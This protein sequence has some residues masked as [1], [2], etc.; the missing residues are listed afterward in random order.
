MEAVNAGLISDMKSLIDSIT[1]GLAKLFEVVTN[2]DADGNV[3]KTF[4]VTLPDKRKVSVDLKPEKNYGFFSL[5]FNVTGGKK[6]VVRG[7]SKNEIEDK[8]FETLEKVYDIPRDMIDKSVKSSRKCIAGLQKVECSDSADIVLTGI[9][10]SHDIPINDIQAMLDS[11]LASDELIEQISDEPI[12]IEISDNGSDIDIETEP[13][14]VDQAEVERLDAIDRQN[15]AAVISMLA[16]VIFMESR[17]RFSDSL[18]ATQLADQIK[19]L[20]DELF[21]AIAS[22]VGDLDVGVGILNDRVM[23]QLADTKIGDAYDVYAV[24]RDRLDFIKF[25]SVNTPS[26]ISYT[27]ETLCTDMFDCIEKYTESVFGYADG[28]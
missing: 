24:I 1:G 17:T 12:F 13:E 26:N 19:S 7:I 10:A 2:E 16:N 6:T 5:E 25:F 15:A 28:Q 27:L 3:I 8:L 4:T 22:S 9:Y 14:F 18:E 21:E 23:E 11:A 20:A